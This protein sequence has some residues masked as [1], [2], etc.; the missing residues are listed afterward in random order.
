[1]RLPLPGHVTRMGTQVVCSQVPQEFDP[2]VLTCSPATC[3]IYQTLL[4]ETVL[5]VITHKRH[6]GPRV[7]VIVILSYVC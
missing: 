5:E 4:M 3:C 1:M 2:A 6:K 7:Y